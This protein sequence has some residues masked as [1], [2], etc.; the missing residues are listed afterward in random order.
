M[1]QIIGCD[2]GE[3]SFA[4]DKADV[5]SIQRTERF[6]YLD[7]SDGSP[8]LDW[9]SDFEQSDRVIGWISDGVQ[10]I[11]ICQLEPPQ[12]G[13]SNLVHNNIR[14]QPDEAA[15]VILFTPK[16][17]QTGGESQP[18]TPPWGLLIDR[19]IG[20]NEVSRK[21]FHATPPILL[22][23]TITAFRSVVRQGGEVRMVLD[24][25]SLNPFRLAS[26]SA[27]FTVYLQ[28]ENHLARVAAAMQV[29][30]GLPGTRGEKPDVRGLVA[31]SLSRS[32]GDGRGVSIGLSISQVAEIL[33]TVD[34]I[35]VPTSP[36]HVGGL[37]FWRDIAVPIVDLTAR[38]GMPRLGDDSG[39]DKAQRYLIVRHPLSVNGHH[40]NQ[41][42]PDKHL[43][44]AALG[45]SSDVRILRSPIESQ[46]S[47]RKLPLRSDFVQGQFELKEETL[48][49]PNLQ[50]LLTMQ[51]A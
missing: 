12:D 4:I 43:I 44:F 33:E 27:D 38:M 10:K 28:D 3:L 2:V 37:I 20:V 22:E 24:P 19:V 36:D 49:I 9:L 40:T 16:V 13:G 42:G 18:M 23:S 51:A 8:D 11:P 41:V 45:T 34:V 31:F 21:H 47:S 5:L 50:A 29:S 30:G 14:S 39:P 6:N 32:F 25:Q 7:R 26:P 48:V 1:A 35:P 46:P 17:S 15:R